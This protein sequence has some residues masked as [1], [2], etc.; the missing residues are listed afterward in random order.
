MSSV[1]DRVVVVSGGGQGLGRAFALDLAEHGWHVGVADINEKKAQE[2]ASQITAN[3]GLALGVGVDVASE[4]SVEAAH[5]AVVN[6]LGPVVGLVN[7]AALFSTLK[8]GPFSDISFEDW[9]QVMRVNVG[10]AFL[11]TRVFTP[12][13]STAGYGKIVNISSATVFGGRAGY[14]HYVTSKAALVGMTRG[15]ASELGPY[16]IRVNTIAPGSTATEVERATIT[17]HDRQAMARATALRRVQ[18]PTDLVGALRFALS[19]D[20]DFVTGQTLV[21]D[22]GLVFH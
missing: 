4:P 8:M 21:V 15:L 10:G 7:N 3:G 1:A 20:S 5:D 12:D 22:G 2:V 6:H 14:L 18:V 9:E 16:G 19:P 13:M 17:A 11:M